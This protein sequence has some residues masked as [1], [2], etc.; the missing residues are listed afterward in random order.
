LRLDYLKTFLTVLETGGF[1]AAAKKLGVS[2]ATVTNHVAILE[3]FFEAKLFDRTV[4]GAEL[5]E[6]G[7]ILKVSA[8]KIL[9]EIEKAKSQISILKG[10][11]VELV[12]IAAS[13][14][15][16]EHLL[17]SI[18]AE[19]KKEHPMAKFEVRIMD[20]GNALSCLKNETVDFAAVGSLIGCENDFEK[21]ELGE[22]EL[23]LIVPKNHGLGKKQTVKLNE[24]LKYPYIN[25]EEA[26]GTRKETERILL[27]A[28]IPPQKL[29]VVLELGSTQAVI[30]AVSEGKGISIISSIAARK[31]EK[32]GL[33]KT[34]KISNA[35]T[36]RKLYLLRQ[37]KEL[38][39]TCEL[40]W[41][42]CQK[43]ET[44]FS[45]IRDNF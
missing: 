15:P 34:V 41:K 5:T 21:L 9:G 33:I 32:S 23:V 30:T 8:E 18:I 38:N 11:T 6:A 3:N 31:A 10:R 43:M 25:R 24:I 29:N 42:F 37:K 19:F 4:K 39:K 44:S 1:L 26:S 27:E 14:I 22:E 45:Q 40:F 35:K 17:P 2:Q 16:G 13:T 7:K 20:T 36:I 12:R 28:K